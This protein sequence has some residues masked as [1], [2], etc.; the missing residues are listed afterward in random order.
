MTEEHAQVKA[1]TH[2]YWDIFAN[3]CWPFDEDV[4]TCGRNEGQFQY[5]DAELSGSHCQFSIE[6]GKCFLK[7]LDSSNGTYLNEKEI[8]DSEAIQLKC[9][10]VVIF[11]RQIIIY[12]DENI[13]KIKEREDILESIKKNIE[14]ENIYNEIKNK[15]LIFMKGHHPRLIIKK[16]VQVVE[17]KIADAY[18]I[19]EDKLSKYD[20]K[21]AE[22]T[23]LIGQH[24]AKIKQL[25]EKVLLIETEKNKLAAKIDPQIDALHAQVQNL[26]DEYEALSDKTIA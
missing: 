25:E 18:N 15:T 12:L 4:I 2:F 7:D 26:E 23:D 5:E 8:A 11:G 10:D 20:N 14:D 19:K 9:F 22:V 21:A 3:T 17:K 24:K 16:K 13:F 6:N 1:W